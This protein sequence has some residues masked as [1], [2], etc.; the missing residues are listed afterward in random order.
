ME[1]TYRQGVNIH[2]LF[3]ALLQSAQA[4][5]KSV[6]KWVHFQRRQTR[7]HFKGLNPT[8][9]TLKSSTTHSWLHI[10]NRLPLRENNLVVFILSA[11]G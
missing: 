11:L 8:S 1:K 9:S 5:N 7:G 4:V 2:V 3:L 10:F 6:K